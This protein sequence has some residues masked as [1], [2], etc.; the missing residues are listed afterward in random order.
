MAADPRRKGRGCLAPLKIRVDECLKLFDQLHHDASFPVSSR[1]GQ[2]DPAELRLL[3]SRFRLWI[4][5]V[6]V[7]RNGTD[8]LVY[9][10]RD[11]SDILEQM[12]ELFDALAKN[13]RKA[14]AILQDESDSSENKEDEEHIPEPS[15]HLDIDHHQYM[16]LRGTQ[17]ELGQLKESIKVILR[18]LATISKAMELSVP[19][20][21]CSHPSRLPPSYTEDCLDHIHQTFPSASKSLKERLSTTMYT[22]RAYLEY[23]K[24]R[25]HSSL[26]ASEDNLDE[27]A[28]QS[29]E[30]GL[31]TSNIQSEVIILNGGLTE[32][33]QDTGP[34]AEASRRATEL[35]FIPGPP[36]FG[37]IFQCP[38]CFLNISAANSN[39]WRSHVYEDLLPYICTFE[40]CSTPLHRF[41]SRNSWF[42]HEMEHISRWRC[43][44][45]C[46]ELFDTRHAL[47]S[48][49][50][51]LHHWMTRA[52]LP[53]GITDACLV[54][55]DGGTRMPCPLC[56]DKIYLSE[57]QTHLGQHQEQVALFAL[58]SRIRHGELERF[59]ESLVRPTVQENQ[60]DQNIQIY[61]C[62]SASEE[63]GPPS[64][65]EV[66]RTYSQSQSVG[67]E[68]PSIL[69]KEE[70]EK[71]QKEMLRADTGSDDAVTEEAIVDQRKQDATENETAKSL[72]SDG[73]RPSDDSLS[74]TPPRK[75]GDKSQ[76]A[77]GNHPE[78]MTAF[79][80]DSSSI[81]ESRSIPAEHS[82][83]RKLFRADRSR[84]AV[85][86]TLFKKGDKVEYFHKGN[87]LDVRKG[88]TVSDISFRETAKGCRYT[89]R[90]DRTTVRGVPEGCIRLDQS[91]GRSGGTTGA[92]NIVEVVPQ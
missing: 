85:S 72:K 67:P 78:A 11:S 63:R 92:F 27:A 17:N 39:S 73:D 12:Y 80:E 58:Q 24:S 79:N 62:E 29:G 76:E 57:L 82:R 60:H 66:R 19:L 91:A 83:T 6:G 53:G 3:A 74:A 18:C 8:G 44:L 28:L 47:A 77:R 71:E 5:K 65:D 25:R 52:D 36:Q 34:S 43:P 14:S 68:I 89:L 56:C 38:L 10:L 40:Q 31:S 55:P 26:L 20:D 54:I 86:A 46:E 30:T 51:D 84:A 81:Q 61:P 32:E 41:Q 49:L 1:V 87:A 33:S 70:E 9:K 13:M 7:F 90:K 75:Q 4:G 50:K 64:V 23:R 88:F 21:F 59:S 42:A 37:E 15:S 2:I 69:A 22:R 16:G 48:H 35:P 45:A